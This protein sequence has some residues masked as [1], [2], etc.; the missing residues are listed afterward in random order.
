LSAFVVCLQ[1]ESASSDAAANA[2]VLVSRIGTSPWFGTPA[3]IGACID[4]RRHRLLPGVAGATANPRGAL[5]AN[6][7]VER[8]VNGPSFEPFRFPLSP[9]RG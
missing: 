9:A 4:W 2:A 5:H 8:E 1:A 6:E 3:M 7:F